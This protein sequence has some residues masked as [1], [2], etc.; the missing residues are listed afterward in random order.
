MLLQIMEVL[1]LWYA[2]TEGVAHVTRYT[3]A[4]WSVT[5]DTT[6]CVYTTHSWTWIY[7][8]LIDAG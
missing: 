8:F 1:T 2:L 3:N 4:V 6:F 7:T 5:N